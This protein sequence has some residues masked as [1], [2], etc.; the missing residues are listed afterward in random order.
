[1]LGEAEMIM[2]HVALVFV[3][4]HRVL[5]AVRGDF[6][7]AAPKCNEINDLDRILKVRFQRPRD[8]C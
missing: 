7:G 4:P 6:C 8:V 3:S 2:V 1:M 5:E